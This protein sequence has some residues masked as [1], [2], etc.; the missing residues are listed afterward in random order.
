[1]CRPCSRATSKSG[2]FVG[3]SAEGIQVGV[4]ITCG[5]L[6]C[7]CT[8][9]RRPLSLFVAGRIWRHT[10]ES[11]MARAIA[12]SKALSDGVVP[13]QEVVL[14][15]KQL[16]PSALLKR[17]TADPNQDRPTIIVFCARCGDYT[18]LKVAGYNKYSSEY[19]CGVKNKSCCGFSVPHNSYYAVQRPP[20]G[21]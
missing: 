2:C 16:T 18:F 20:R 10:A 9:I 19:W 14:N 3:T 7:P 21:K 8:R 12:K 15:E 1:M 13:P 17:Y 4:V 6:S 5:S 11:S